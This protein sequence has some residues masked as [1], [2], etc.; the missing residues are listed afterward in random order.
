MSA[1]SL[2]GP[3][4]PSV[5]DRPSPEH[6]YTPQRPVVCVLIT[7]AGNAHGTSAADFC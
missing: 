2:P 4:S 3:A 7:V 1:S 5:V 6:K